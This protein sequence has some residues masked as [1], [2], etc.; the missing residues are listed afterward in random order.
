MFQLDT[1]YAQP[2][3][4]RLTDE[5]EHER[6]LACLTA[7]AGYHFTLTTTPPATSSLPT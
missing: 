3:Q 5:A 6:A 4:H 1:A 2:G 7:G